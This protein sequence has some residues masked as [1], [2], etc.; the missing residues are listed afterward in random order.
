MFN[1]LRKIRAAQARK[2]AKANADSAWMQAKA[3]HD[4]AKN[5]RQTQV[6]HHAA[7]TLKSAQTARLELELGR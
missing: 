4:L 5:A 6:Q 1:F 7:L 2:A 3:R